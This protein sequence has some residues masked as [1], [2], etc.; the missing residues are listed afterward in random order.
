V[1]ST[2]EPS[3]YLQNETSDRR[4]LLLFVMIVWLPKGKQTVGQLVSITVGSPDQDGGVDFVEGM[5]HGSGS[6]RV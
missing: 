3:P 4:R 5:L 6:V 2:R 1:S